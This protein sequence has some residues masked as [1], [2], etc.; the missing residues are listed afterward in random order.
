MTIS[1]I[2]A[3]S[4]SNRKAAS[5]VKVPAEIQLNSVSRSSRFS[6]G[7]LSRSEKDSAAKIKETR[8]ASEPAIPPAFSPRNFF[9]KKPLSRKPASGAARIHFRSG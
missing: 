1:A 4:G 7:R 9:P 8:M 3:D 2:T 5:T 6:G